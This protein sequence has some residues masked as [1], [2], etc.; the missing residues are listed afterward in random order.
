MANSIGW[1]QGASNNSIGWGQ[2]SINNNIAWGII[3]GLSYS[4]ETD[5]TGG[6]DYLVTFSNNFQ[7]R[8]ST[9]SGIFEG[10]S[11]LLGFINGDLS[12]GGALVLP[13]EDRVFA[14][15]GLFESDICL[16][17]FVNSLT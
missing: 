11:C 2:G 13:F 12:N 8:I 3:H 5:I 7:S 16:I 17:N 1:G 9:D 14:D 10:G 6:L 4:G 15:S